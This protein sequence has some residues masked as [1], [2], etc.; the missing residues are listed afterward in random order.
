[1]WAK[2]DQRFQ[3]EGKRL[4]VEEKPWA[5]PALSY[6]LL[7]S[8]RAELW[9]QKDEN[10]S[11]HL[12]FPLIILQ[13]SSAESVHESPAALSP[14]IRVKL[15]TWILSF[16]NLPADWLEGEGDPV[17]GWITQFSLLNFVH[18]SVCIVLSIFFTAVIINKHHL[19]TSRGMSVNHEER[20]HDVCRNKVLFCWRS[21]WHP[22]SHQTS[23]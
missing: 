12:H 6:R 9:V 10:T 5:I 21:R 13:I 7:D 2:E 19:Q 23:F 3:S 22:K 8:I 20:V 17:K 4:K 16:L 11:K 15:P 1:M 14:L 18:T